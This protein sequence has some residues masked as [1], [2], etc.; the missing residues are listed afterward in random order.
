MSFFFLYCQLSILTIDEKQVQIL[1][2]V[3]C[4]CLP[5][6]NYD[7]TAMVIVDVIVIALYLSIQSNIF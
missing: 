5:D 4:V 3:F 1:N 7:R 2:L 6:N